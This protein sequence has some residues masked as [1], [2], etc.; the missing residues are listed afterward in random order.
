MKFI[1]KEI[2]SSRT[3]IR[4]SIN[5]VEIGGQ[6]HY[7]FGTVDGLFDN[8]SIKPKYIP[9][10]N[11]LYLSTGP[12]PGIIRLLVAYLKDFIGSPESSREYVLTI[13]SQQVKIPIVNIAI[14]DINLVTLDSQ[15]IPTILIKLTEELPTDFDVLQDVNI[16]KHIFTTQ[17]Q[18]VYYIPKATVEPTFYGLDYDK[19]S[20][21]QVTTTDTR[22]Y[23]YDNYNELT[24]SFD[25]D[26]STVV[27]NILSASDD[28]LKIN[29][30]T[31]ENHVYYGS[32]VA[33]LRNFKT[34]VQR[35]ENEINLISQS[36]NLTSSKSVND[37]RIASF[38]KIQEEKSSLKN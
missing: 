23:S 20:I 38:N 4:L 7:I 15:T 13:D 5:P 18:N 25:L 9:P 36:L 35:I 17:E 19:D 6:F 3:E 1:I 21:S 8:N 30:K 22:K 14:D 16:E 28:N 29:Y 11:A 26:D 31:F 32:A 37:L 24:A 12:N 33:K 27:H 10:Q 34:K 2:S